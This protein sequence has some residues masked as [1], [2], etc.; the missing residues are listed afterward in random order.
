MVIFALLKRILVL[1][2]L[3]YVVVYALPYFPYIGDYVSYFFDDT[4]E[5]I[6]GFAAKNIVAPIAETIADNA[7]AIADSARGVE[8]PSSP[9]PASKFFASKNTQIDRPSNRAA[10]NS[11]SPSASSPS[12]N[13]EPAQSSPE[14]SSENSKGLPAGCCACA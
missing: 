6:T 5:A 11:V 4:K 10:P 1:M 8:S 2:A 9:A 12:N 3:F 13:I 14:S 7:Q